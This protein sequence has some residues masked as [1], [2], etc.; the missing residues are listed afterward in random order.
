MHSVTF[1]F[2]HAADLHLDDPFSGVSATAPEVASVLRDASLGAFDA[3]VR[4]AIARDVSFV[5]LSGGLYRGAVRGVRAQLEL[6][7]G[8][9]ELS[10]RG[11]RTFVAL[12]DEDPLEEGW[13]AI[14]EW[15]ALVTVFPSD[16]P[17]TVTV[18]RDGSV[19][20][21]V[22]GIS[23]GSRSAPDT[24]ATRLERTDHPGLHVGVVHAT[25]VGPHLDA[26]P[27]AVVAPC[28]IDALLGSGIDYWALGHLHRHL[29]VHREPWVVHPGNT[30]ARRAAGDEMGPKGVCLVE[31][32][33]DG[34]V[35]E[36]EFVPVDRVRF[37]Q[38]DCSIEG[39]A[40]LA[41]LRDRLVDLGR[42]RLAAA[43]GRSVL[44]HV[45]LV[46][47]GPAHDELHRPGAMAELV[48]HVRSE[49]L[50][51][52]PLLW[53]DRI[54]VHTRA[55]RDLDDLQGRNDFVADLV[56]ETQGLLADDEARSRRVHDWGDDLPSDLTHLLDGDLPDP[57][58]PDRWLQAQQLAI[59]LVVG[60]ES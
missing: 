23:H 17:H 19:L 39:S 24:L 58:D 28:D 44:L 55:V 59:E 2:L 21:T 1:R 38:V 35:T 32:S 57:T 18:E 50:S 48:E 49:S 16:E 22:H 46:G 54:S 31:V 42:A 8:L 43:D 51:E 14:G 34:T 7:R 27:E 47:S 36:L 10:D 4:V 6:H 15:P 30:Q 12:G 26:A 29:V 45:D 3:L 41:T 9:S 60:D 56:E 52:P 20:A 33:D 13:T 5:V 11:I 53:W 25:A 40:D 37:D